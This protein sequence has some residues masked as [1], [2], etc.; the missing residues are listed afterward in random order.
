MAVAM[1]LGYWAYVRFIER[2]AAA[3]LTPRLRVTLVA[4][5]AAIVLIGAP[6]ML[7]YT[8]G[9]YHLVSYRGF[10][11][12]W[13][14]I[15][16]IIAVGVFEELVFRGLVFTLLERATGSIIA[17][18]LQAVIFAVPHMFNANFS[19]WMDFFTVAL[20]GTMWGCLYI[21]WRNIWA[22]AL[23]HAV[24]NLTIVTTGLPLSGL[25]DYRASAPF[26]STYHGPVLLTGGA[27]G[28]EP[29]V[30]TLALAAITLAALLVIAHRG[31]H[32]RRRTAA[33]APTRSTKP[34]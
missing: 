5:I 15:P 34:I 30:V 6:V 33:A 17:L 7:L 31:G 14:V 4:V 11:A 32:L 23:H 18:I 25:E 8:F 26:H 27:G 9:Y 10:A 22:L 13:V 12:F 29:S 2:R 19:D 16:P 20:I 28:P 1:T 21:L 3:E 24:W